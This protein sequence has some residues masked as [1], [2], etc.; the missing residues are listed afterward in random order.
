MKKYTLLALVLLLSVSVF[1]RRSSSSAYPNEPM[2]P[3]AKTTATHQRLVGYAYRQLTSS[4]TT[5]SVCFMYQSLSHGSGTIRWN[6]PLLPDPLATPQVIK[7]DSF[8][9]DFLGDE[10]RGR[11]YYNTDNLATYMKMETPG[12]SGLTLRSNSFYY[13]D[14]GNRLVTDS[15]YYASFTTSYYR[16]RTFDGAGHLITDSTY[17]ATA[18]AP[19]F[20]YTYTNNAAGDPVFATMDI[21]NITTASWDARNRTTTTYDGSGR[22]VLAITEQFDGITWNDFAKDTMGYTGTWPMYTYIANFGWS[23]TEWTGSSANSYVLDATG[24][25]D[26][27]WYYNWNSATMS[28]DTTEKDFLIYNTA[29]NI[30]M[31]Q[32]IRYNTATHTYDATPYDINRFYYEDYDDVNVTTTTPLA[33]ISIYP[34]PAGSNLYI[35]MPAAMPAT[36]VHITDMTG[37]TMLSTTLDNVSGASFDVSRYAPG[38]YIITVSTDGNSM[39]QVLVKQ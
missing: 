18:G 8:Y 19:V 10:Y 26:T 21:W 2:P 6:Q 30:S 1:A 23:G 16:Y 11:I 27:A 34:N 32:G 20:K 5:D 25:W 33:G 29:G 36:Q 3:S 4:V 17:D 13:Y 9:Y 37:R 14:A 35:T 7:C 38:S 22:K 31:A 12:I 39:T 15:M 28:F 24:H